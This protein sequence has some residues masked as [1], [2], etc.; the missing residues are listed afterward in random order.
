MRKNFKKSLIFLIAV[1]FL[2]SFV[3]VGA[4][5]DDD[6]DDEDEKSSSRPIIKTDVK[7]STKTII[8]RDGDGD[9]IFDE[10]DPHPAIAEI[11]IVEDN[12]RNGIV[13]KFEK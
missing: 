8:L 3:S 10:D 1:F 11:Y 2:A 13:D 6:D 5:D 7:T 4:D 9:G 12:N